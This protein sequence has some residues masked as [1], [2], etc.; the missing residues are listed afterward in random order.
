M[1]TFFSYQ[2]I[3]SLAEKNRHSGECLGGKYFIAKEMILVDEVS[4]D[5]IEEIVSDLINENDLK[6]YFSRCGGS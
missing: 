4:R 1:A 6:T 3:L 2:N 5:R